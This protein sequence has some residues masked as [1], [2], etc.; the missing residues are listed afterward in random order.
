[1]TNPTMSYT[2][3]WTLTDEDTTPT[4]V[5]YSAT[6]ANFDYTPV[7]AG[8]YQIALAATDEYQ[9]F[10]ASPIAIHVTQVAP[11]AILNVSSPTLASGG[12]AYSV[13][14]SLANAYDPSPTENETGNQQYYIAN[15]RQC[16]S[17]PSLPSYTSG[18]TTRLERDVYDSL[19]RR[20]HVLGQGRRYRRTFHDLPQH[21]L[22]Q[23]SGVRARGELD[24]VGELRERH[25]RQ[26]DLYGDL[27]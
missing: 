17:Q 10:A 8:N 7:V 13:V 24:F 16:A 15:A 22:G 23:Q 18:A 2:Y 6:G 20:L 1:M 27:Q 19:C 12:A 26:R 9:T 11:T 25:K 4:S 5:T 21:G 14:A 3:Q